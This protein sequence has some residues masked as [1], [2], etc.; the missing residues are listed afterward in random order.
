MNNKIMGKR[1]IITEEEKRNIL[2]QYGIVSEQE[3]G[4]SSSIPIYH[5][6]MVDWTIR[7]GR[8]FYVEL[9]RGTLIPTGWSDFNGNLEEFKVDV[10]I[11]RSGNTGVIPSDEIKVLDV[12]F[13]H[14]VDSITE[15]YKY[16]DDDLKP[17]QQRGFKFLCVYNNQI[18]ICTANVRFDNL[19]QRGSAEVIMDKRQ[20]VD[21]KDGIILTPYTYVRANK[22]GKPRKNGDYIYWLRLYIGKEGFP[23]KGEPMEYKPIEISLS[24]DLTDLFEFDTINF[25]NE[26]EAFAQMDTLVEQINEL[27]EKLNDHNKERLKISISKTPIEG[28]ASIDRSPDDTEIG[29]YSGCQGKTTNG[30]YNQCLSEARAAVVRDYLN[31]KLKDKDIKFKSIG[32]GGT[33]QFGGLS[34]DDEGYDGPDKS[35]PNRRVRFNLKD[36]TF[37]QM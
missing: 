6:G 35:A 1:I 12:Y 33:K 16:F 9:E 29:Y 21:G 13:E 30:E 25:S 17:N 27:W 10:H 34:Y 18:H 23:V 15:M 37:R 28:F 8:V 19:E 24:L 2:G 3:D 4:F 5:A 26:S 32:R 20:Q 22:R 36:E 7:N 31:E 14:N 11:N